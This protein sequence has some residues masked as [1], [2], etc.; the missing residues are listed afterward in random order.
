LVAWARARGIE[1]LALA[2]RMRL[3]GLASDEIE[4]FYFG[5][6][7]H[8]TEAGHAYVAG[9]MARAFFGR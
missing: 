5:G 7:G 8:F 3:D 2:E 1:I 9:A 4:S 6:T